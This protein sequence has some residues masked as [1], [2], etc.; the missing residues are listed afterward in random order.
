MFTC[1]AIPL[2]G[3]CASFIHGGAYDSENSRMAGRSHAKDP[4][5][6]AGS[7]TSQ[8]KT[9]DLAVEASNAVG[10]PRHHRLVID[11]GAD[12]L[13]PGSCPY[14]YVSVVLYFGT[15]R[16]RMMKNL[17][18]LCVLSLL[19]FH[20][21]AEA[22]DV[23]GMSC[24]SVGHFVGGVIAERQQ[25]RTEAQQMRELHAAIIMDGPGY[26][27]LE[28]G[29]SK[30]IHSIYGKPFW[31]NVDPGTAENVSIGDCMAKR[32]AAP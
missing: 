19:P 18:A 16:G 7:D 17:V 31:M 3:D 24:E 8:K 4:I 26:A 6:K 21:N 23:D 32:Q 9:A 5:P 14:I 29:L 15:G 30:I 10:T 13:D 28:P 11:R 2:R 25:G 27:K 20:V 1:T 22:F 12:H